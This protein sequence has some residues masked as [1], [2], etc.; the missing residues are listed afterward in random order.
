MQKDGVVSI[1][2]ANTQWSDDELREVT[3]SKYSDDGDYLGSVFTN[4]L[5][6]DYVDDDFLEA[7]ILAETDSITEALKGFSYESKILNEIAKKNLALEKAIDTAVLIYNYEFD[8]KNNP[9]AI[10]N[11]SFFF[12]GSFRYL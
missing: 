9:C 7:E 1:W 12:L 3:A 8:G 4:A 2:T 11:Q 10:S 6:L 5:S